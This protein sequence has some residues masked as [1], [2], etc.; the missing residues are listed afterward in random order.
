MKIQMHE[1]IW[2]TVLLIVVTG[3]SKNL[4]ASPPPTLFFPQQK[5]TPNAIMD[6]L[7]IGKLVLV[8]NCLRVNDENDNSFLPIWPRGF[9]AR[10]N[11]GII[12]VVDDQDQLIAQVGDNLRIGGGEMPGQ[13]IKE[14][15]LQPLPDDCPGP[16]WLVGDEITRP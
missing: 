1:S 6:A 3:C 2:I 4:G 5:E 7:L 16:Y 12:E 14:D 13:H 15:T 8:N 11:D 10:L 9:S